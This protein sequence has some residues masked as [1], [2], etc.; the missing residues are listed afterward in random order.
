MREIPAWAVLERRLFDQIEEAWRAFAERYCEPDGRLR[1]TGTLPTRDGVDDFYEPFFN[2]PAFYE[3]GGSDE[4]LA[5]AKHHWLGVTAHMTELG[6]VTDEYENGYDWFHQGE[7]LIFFY[8]LCAAAPDDRA[9]RER[10]GRF[11]QLYADPSRG[12]YDPEAN[13]IRAPHNG[14]LGA[15][16]GVEWP[17]YPASQRN[18][19]P[20]GLPL[21]YL[22]GIAQWSDLEDPVKAEQMGAAMQHA[23]QGDVAVNLAATS[24]VVNRWLYDGDPAAA[25]WV[26][27]YVDGWRERADGLGGLLPDSVGP[28]GTVGGM[29]GGRWY[30]GHYG[31]T[32][33]HGLPSVAM[34][35][36]IGA[37]NAVIVTGDDSYLDLARVPLD[38]VLEHAVTASVSETPM[39]LQANWLSRLGA[40][41][42]NPATLVPHR[43]GRDGWFDYG[44]M[45]LDLPTWLWWF[46]RDPADWARLRRLMDS[47]P[48]DP[49]AV[50]PFRD[51][52][53]SGH[54]LPWLSYLAHEN[55]TYPERALSMA[56]GQ[57]ARRVA[58]M[59]SENPDPATV[60]I[61]FWQRVNPVVTEVL[62]Q[63]VG[64]APQ[65]LYNGGLPLVAVSYTDV[66]RG[67][68]GLPPD[69]AALVSSIEGDRIDLELVNLS[70]TE[71]R[72]LAIRPG[73]FGERDVATVTAVAEADGVYPGTPVAYTSTPGRAVMHTFRIDAPEVLVTLPPNHRAGLTLTI[74]DIIRPARH[75]RGAE[76]TPTEESK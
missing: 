20:Y 12:N 39:S 44:P 1:F 47:Y 5:A 26:V 69:V 61:H 67:R 29:H 60:H 40:D 58:L 3:L 43:Y 28:D 70:M 15:L 73:R 76:P 50:K 62:T 30:G 35:A 64:G 34:G 38:T 14:A 72:R 51:K 10:A 63:L 25:A 22:P 13:I 65:V 45:P 74:T 48:E 21:E 27:R 68:P 54:E 31:W 17:T 56:L 24:L 59:E 9:F 53:E 23:A 36:L 2:W 55:P 66:D 11:A 6:M 19:E 41:A 4:V 49:T 37:I 32:W 16:E 8:A 57:V 52:A 7:S 18:M 46:S 33:P 42:D 75:R 71:A